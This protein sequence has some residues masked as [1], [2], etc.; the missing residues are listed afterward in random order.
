MTPLKRR[1]KDGGGKGLREGGKAGHFPPTRKWW[2][3]VGWA[4]ATPLRRRLSEREGRR[5]MVPAPCSKIRGGKQPRVKICCDME[6]CE[7][8][9]FNTYPLVVDYLLRSLNLGIPLSNLNPI[10]GPACFAAGI[11]ALPTVRRGCDRGPGSKMGMK[12]V[13]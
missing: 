7:L 13:D 11:K 3:D 4:S 5:S 12:R 2:I 6:N 10:V 8:V 9:R 1:K